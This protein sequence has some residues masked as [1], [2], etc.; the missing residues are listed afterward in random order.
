MITQLQKFWL[1]V[2]FALTIINSVSAQA[3][4][5]NV[6]QGTYK[7]IF[8][9]L[10]D[11]PGVEVKPSNNKSG[12]TVIVRGVGSL[13]NQKP[14]L[15]VV[16]GVI[17]NGDITNINPQDVDMVSVLKDAAS[18]SVYGAQGAGG[19]IVINTKKG[20]NTTNN[21]TVSSHT[22]SAYTYFIEHKTNLSVFGM[23][24]KIIVKGVIQSQRNEDLIFIVKR[25]ELVV[26]IKNILRVEMIND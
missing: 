25:K 3:K 4:A 22:E 15:Y 21:P 2:F 24:E 6:T 14:P 20:S 5:N 23:D 10:K 1:F 7:T 17:Y 26:P 19:V 11:V 18:T 16:D 8:E 9:M 12:G 13:N